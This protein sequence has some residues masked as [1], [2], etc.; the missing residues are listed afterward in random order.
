MWSVNCEVYCVCEVWCQGRPH[1]VTAGRATNPLCDHLLPVS[2]ACRTSGSRLYMYK[3]L[4]MRPPFAQSHSW[5]Y[6]RV[7]SMCKW[8]H[9]GTFARMNKLF[10]SF[11]FLLGIITPYCLH[12]Y[13]SERVVWH[14][15]IPPTFD[16][17]I[18]HSAYIRYILL[19]LLL[20]NAAP[21]SPCIFFRLQWQSG[22][23]ACFHW[24][25]TSYGWLWR[26][27]QL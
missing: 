22:S 20:P 25:M 17:G 1:T 5:S 27:F 18:L 21:F 24:T 4:N 8:L 11:F 2:T 16:Q 15:S 10:S 19:L 12:E 23:R 14:D 7:S 13:N 3:Q 6:K 26:S 9:D